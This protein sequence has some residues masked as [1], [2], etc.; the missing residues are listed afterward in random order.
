M[1]FFE[2]S[3]YVSYVDTLI[4]K[5]TFY[6]DLTLGYLFPK[7]KSFEIDEPEDF[8]IAEAI[9]QAKLEGKFKAL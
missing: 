7:W 8:L 4:Q 3:L 2:G 9:M 6:H 1:Y 5:K